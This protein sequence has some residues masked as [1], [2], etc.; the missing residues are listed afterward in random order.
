MVRSLSG[1]YQLIIALKID[2]YCG[3]ID[4]K[5]GHSVLLQSSLFER[6]SLWGIDMTVENGI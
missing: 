1:R 2:F 4:N 6:D 5:G 3:I